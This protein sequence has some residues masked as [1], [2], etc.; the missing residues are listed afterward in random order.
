M[1]ARA[2]ADDSQ[3]DRLLIERGEVR[4]GDAGLMVTIT[5]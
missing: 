3:I 1:H 4:K 2:Y 5:G